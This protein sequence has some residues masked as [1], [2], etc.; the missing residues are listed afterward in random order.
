MVADAEK[1]FPEQ[2]ERL[3]L[4]GIERAKIKIGAG[5]Q[6]D[7][8]R[9]SIARKVLGDHIGIIVDANGNYTVDEALNS[10]R[11]IAEYGARMVRGAASA[12]R[13]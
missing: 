12:A 8:E 1:D 11:R 6:S 9:V 4:T 7:R 10:M 2:L 3:R 13:L 5:S